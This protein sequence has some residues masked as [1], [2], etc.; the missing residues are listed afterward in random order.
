VN[1]LYN[2]IFSLTEDIQ[3]SK[4]FLSDF[5]NKGVVDETDKIYEHIPVCHGRVVY[6]FGRLYGVAS[7]VTDKLNTEQ[8]GRPS[9]VPSPFVFFDR[10]FSPLRDLFSRED[11]SEIPLI[12]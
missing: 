2:Y 8:S 5:S 11:G 10:V 12:R 6:F 1:L 3:F 9:S 4:I 7:F